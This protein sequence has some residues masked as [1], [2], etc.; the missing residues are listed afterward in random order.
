LLTR[1]LRQRV[2][3]QGNM[4]TANRIRDNVLNGLLRAGRCGPVGLE[5]MM[6][7]QSLKWAFFM[8]VPDSILP[9]ARNVTVAT[10]L[11][12]A[13]I[14]VWVAAFLGAGL[15]QLLG[16][17]SCRPTLRKAI[18]LCGVFVWLFMAL[19]DALVNGVNAATVNLLLMA[20]GQGMVVVLVDVNDV[21][22]LWPRFYAK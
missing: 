13:S 20:L 7:L 1:T 17:F 14:W 5:I 4:G 16:A 12:V 3:R 15:G 10:M 9:N 11:I 2:W 8:V 22:M 6:A 21:A 18:A 19:I